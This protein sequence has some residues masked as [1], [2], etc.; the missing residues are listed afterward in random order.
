MHDARS[1]QDAA[2]SAKQ[3]LQTTAQQHDCVWSKSCPASPR[4]CSVLCCCW[5]AAAAT[6]HRPVVQ[7][8]EGIEA[9]H[10]CTPA[11]CIDQPQECIASY[12]RHSSVAC[13]S[14]VLQYRC[15]VAPLVD[16][17]GDEETS[18]HTSSSSVTVTRRRCMYLIPPQLAKIHPLIN[19]NSVLGTGCPGTACA[20]EMTRMSD[21]PHAY[22][23]HLVLTCAPACHSATMHAHTAMHTH[24]HNC[25]ACRRHSSMLMMMTRIE[26]IKY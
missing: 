26:G 22:H 18:T 20:G 19:T 17:P 9:T 4:G 11:A 25:T 23:L 7:V 14:V 12:P 24:T 16:D 15:L 3:T 5:R 8:H 10:A 1:P 2:C 21:T 13:P 6:L